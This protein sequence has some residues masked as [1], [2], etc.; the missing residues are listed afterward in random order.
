MFNETSVKEFEK[1]FKR[2]DYLSIS[3]CKSKLDKLGFYSNREKG[4]YI[5]NVGF[6]IS[7]KSLIR[8][9]DIPNEFKLLVTELNTTKFISKKSF[10]KTLQ[11][12]NNENEKRNPKTPKDFVMKKTSKGGSRVNPFG[13]KKPKFKKASGT[14]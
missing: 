1:T 10:T 12:L 11:Y 4:I 13:K 8:G 7:V 3:E 6:Y 9:N 14:S 2:S 5:N